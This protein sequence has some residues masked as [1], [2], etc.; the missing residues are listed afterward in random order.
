MTDDMVTLTIDGQDVLCTADLTVYRAAALAG[1]HIPTFCNHEKLVPVGA[2]RMCLVEIEGARGLQTS[3]TTPV[4]DGMVVRVH[5]SPVAVKARRANIEFLLTN[6]PLDCPVCDKGGECPLQNQALL[7]GPGQSRY[8][9]ERRHKN[10]RY[11]LGDLI[12]L[13][14]ERCVL[15]WR[16]IR[17]LDEW[18]D[19]HE[20]DLFGRGAGTMLDTFPGRPLRSK[21]QGNTIDIC[22]VGALTSRVFRFEA[23]V[24]ELTNVPSVCPMCPV[25][26]NIYLG[27][28]NNKVRRVVPRENMEVNDAWLCDKGRFAH[29]FIDHPDRL[30]TPMIRRDGELQPAT[31]DEAL[32]LVA[33]RFCEIMEEQGPQAVAGLGSTRVTNE[34]NYLFQRFMRTVVGSNSVDHLGR[35]PT[36][37]IPLGSLP[38]IEERD[39][40][41]LLGTDPSTE[42][43]LV[44]LWIK[45]VALRHGARVVVANPRQIELG[46]YG[47]PWL[48]YQPGS[49]AVLLTGLARAILDAGL[50]S[51]GSQGS[52]GSTRVPN[53][54]DFQAA[55]QAYSPEQVTADTGVPAANLREAARVLIEAANP[56]L[57]YGGTGA[58]DLSTPAPSLLALENLCLLLGGIKARFLADDNN[59]LGALEMGVVPDLFPGRRST[60]DAQSR[61]RNR[62]A[63][64]WGGRLSPVKG[65]GFDAMLA[66]ARQGSLEAMWIMGSDPATD[67]RVSGDALGRVPFLVVQDLFMTDTASLAEVVLP[68]ASFAEA[69]GSYINMTGRLQAVHTAKRPPGQAKAD[70]WIIAELARRMVDEQRQKAW[71]FTAAEDVFDEICRV[72]AGY[73]GLSLSQLDGEGWQ[74]PLAEETTRRSFLPLRPEPSVL[75]PDYP[76]ILVTGRTFYDR[77]TLLSR[78]EAV[79]GL[80]PEAHVLVNPSDAGIYGLV[81]GEE[82]AVESADGMLSL[83]VRI[84]PGIAPGVAFVPSNLSDAPVSV[85]FTDRGS[86]P[87]VRITK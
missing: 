86:A 55:L 57:L 68:A 74:Q 17:F 3:C 23:R 64:V 85:L 22:P 60:E 15:C 29:G 84:D 24:W 49:E 82:A 58:A 40:I 31:W 44:E 38:E 33:R 63:G 61:V 51:R 45:K 12:V 36:S 54:G 1:I 27:V 34:A 70:W 37:A 73:R 83:S 10:K 9:E 11:P 21:W 76:L 75:D 80:V 5:T 19:D 30:Q 42:A 43:P 6:H 56:L 32:D 7:D 47:G 59:T 65:L 25:G 79:Q 13:D 35:M 62:L 39:V 18:A 48:G 71:E 81:D 72:I 46:R 66:A 77:G 78:A 87:R 2:C 52:G 41:F 50:D 20:L 8:V 16:C 67:C 4:L 28:K 53:M 26:C 69:E 14:Q